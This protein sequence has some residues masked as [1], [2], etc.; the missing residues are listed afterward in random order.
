MFPA[1]WLVATA[2]CHIAVAA[3]QP[4]RFLSIA[5][6]H[7]PIHVVHGDSVPSLTS[8]GSSDHFFAAERTVSSATGTTRTALW[9]GTGTGATPPLALA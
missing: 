1:F 6:A 7:C 2:E 3:A 4:S 8:A 9:K 5:V